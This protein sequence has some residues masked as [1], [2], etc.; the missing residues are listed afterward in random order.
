MADIKIVR[1]TPAIIPWLVGLGLVVL[2]LAI[3]IGW[4]RNLSPES[5]GG[6]TPAGTAGIADDAMSGRRLPEEVAAYQSFVESSGAAAVGLSHDYASTGIRRLSAALRAVAAPEMSTNAELSQRLS[7]FQQKADR[8]QTDPQSSGHANI[9]KEV[10]V[11]AVDVMASME[12]SRSSGSNAVKNRIAD[13]R[14]LAESIDAGRPLLDQNEQVTR[15][16]NQ[17]AETLAILANR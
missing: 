9:V 4:D 13:L 5:D 10:F 17:S 1:K 11:S 15:F 12:E 16:F 6:V 2:V 3:W 8:L 14:Q 7:M